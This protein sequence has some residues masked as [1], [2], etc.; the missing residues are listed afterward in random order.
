[1]VYQLFHATNGPGGTNIV[2]NIGP[3]RPL[4]DRTGLPV[5]NPHGD[6]K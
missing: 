6:K 4:L 3:P 5:T 1:M 2:E